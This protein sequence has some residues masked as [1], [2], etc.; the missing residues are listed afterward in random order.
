MQARFRSSSLLDSE[1]AK[2]SHVT[3]QRRV[4]FSSA[5]KRSHG[6]QASCAVLLN[7]RPSK[8]RSL[9]VTRVMHR[10]R[11]M[12]E[13]HQLTALES[14][15]I[16]LLRCGADTQLPTHAYSRSLYSGESEKALQVLQRALSL[17]KKAGHHRWR[18]DSARTHARARVLAALAACHKRSLISCAVVPC[19]TVDVSMHL[20]HSCL[21]A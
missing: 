1:R 21:Q 8:W 14:S 6:S 10:R 16:H 15:A 20:T 9:S 13:N 19:I 12:G 11:E 5:T 4:F 18:S 17:T 3:S 7:L 2:V